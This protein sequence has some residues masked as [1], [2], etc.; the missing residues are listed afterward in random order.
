MKKIKGKNFIFYGVNY[1]VGFGFLATISS[2]IKTGSYSI[3]V[4]LI[5]SLI[6]AGVMLAFSRGSQLYGNEVGGSYVYVKKAFPKNRFFWYVNGWN[7]FMQAPLFSAT[8]PLF[9]INIIQ[10]FIKDNSV[11]Q[12]YSFLIQILALLFFISLTII[13]ALNFK[14]STKVI[15]WSAVVKWIITGIIFVAVIYL[16]TQNPT[17][18]FLKADAKVTPYLIISSILTFIYAYGGVEGLAGLS[19]EVKTKNFR[20]I[21][22]IVFGII[23]FIYILFYLLFLFIPVTSSSNSSYTAV[24]LESA[25]GIAGLIIFTV[26]LLFRQ[27]TSTVFSMIYYAKSVAPLSLDGFL[28]ASLGKVAKNGQHRNAVIF[29]TV[30]SIIAMIIFTILPSLLKVENQFST[31][32]QAGNLVFFLQYLFALIAML[33]LA[34][35]KKLNLKIPLWEKIIYI[36]VSILIIFI[37]LVTFIPPILGEAY[38]ASS[39]IIIGG[40]VV[41]MLIG[42]IFWGLYVLYK[43]FKSLKTK[44]EKI[45]KYIDAQNTTQTELLQQAEK[46]NLEANQTILWDDQTN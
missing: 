35:N 8:A 12:K 25:L 43:E 31:I 41:F 28:P 33:A 11:L 16:V 34:Y 44:I 38:N 7:Q 40:Y 2:V 45:E 30:I 32:L 46:N 15:L 13:S 26:G 27:I 21:L 1:I 18:Q 29:S 42:F 3:L 17:Q 23:I 5:T 22:L 9:F 4:F 37:M 20:K 14:I 19:T 6:A 36:T 24:I 39:A 10:L